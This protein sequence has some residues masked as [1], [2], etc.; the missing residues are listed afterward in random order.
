MPVTALQ[1]DWAAALGFDA[2]A[3]WRPWAPDRHHQPAPPNRR[4]RPLH[5]RGSARR[6]HPDRA[7]PPGALSRQRR[8]RAIIYRCVLLRKPSGVQGGEDVLGRLIDGE[9]RGVDDS[10][11][12]LAEVLERPIHLLDRRQLAESRR[13]SSTCGSASRN[14]K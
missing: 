10:A 4:L 11:L 5:G 14:L 2:A 7:Q 9:F 13:I 3:L 12:K 1:Q 6:D 8:R